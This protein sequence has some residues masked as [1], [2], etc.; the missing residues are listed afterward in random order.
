MSSYISFLSGWSLLDISGGPRSTQSDIK[1][2]RI[3][4]I[5]AVRISLLRFVDPVQTDVEGRAVVCR[6]RAAKGIT[7][8][9]AHFVVIRK[10]A[11]P[12]S[13]VSRQF[14]NPG[15]TLNEQGHPPSSKHRIGD[16]LRVCFP[17]ARILSVARRD[18]RRT[19]RCFHAREVI[20]RV[21]RRFKVNTIHRKTCLKSSLYRL[22]KDYYSVLA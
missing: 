3:C 20:A 12:P 16:V 11:P 22:D 9:P 21:S 4:D 15:F 2:G 17:M 5:S 8:W 18:S 13:L 19:R 14:S 7:G 10:R 1:R 6:P